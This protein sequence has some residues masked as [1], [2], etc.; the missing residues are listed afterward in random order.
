[1]L[2]RKN[3]RFFLVSILHS[4]TGENTNRSWLNGYLPEREIQTGIG[5]VKIRVPNIRDKSRQGI[6]FNS[7]L[8]PPYLRKTRSVEDVLPWLYLKGI[9]TGDFQEVLQALLG[10]EAK[11]LSASTI[12]RCK[13]IR[14]EDNQTWNSRSLENKRYIYIWADGVYFKIRSDHAKQCILIIIS[15]VRLE[16]CRHLTRILKKITYFFLDKSMR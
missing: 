5:P 1:M 11:V 3:C 2:W 13:K 7:M 6:K 10:S 4:K 16:N 15:N 9:F 14:E 12:S 8:L